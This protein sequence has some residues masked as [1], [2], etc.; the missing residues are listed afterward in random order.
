MNFHYLD[1]SQ[2]STLISTIEIDNCLFICDE[3][4]FK[5]CFKK[6]DCNA[7]YVILPAGEQHKNWQSVELVIDKLIELDLNRHVQIFN[8]GG[9]VICDIGGF[10]A[11]I[12]QRGVRF[13]N[14]PTSLM[15]MVDAAYGGKT[16][17][18]YLNI[19]NYIGSFNHPE[20]IYICPDFLSTLPEREILSA[21]AEIIKH[22]LLQGREH[23]LDLQ[24]HKP[25]DL[26]QENWDIL[27]RQS[28][29]FK[30]T[31]VEADFKD[32]GIRQSLNFGHTIGHG[33]ESTLLQRKVDTA[34]GEAVAAGIICELALS[35]QLLNFP[36]DLFNDVQ[37]RIDSIYTRLPIKKSDVAE[38][39]DYASKD[40]KNSNGKIR[41]CLL[42]DLGLPVLN[43][44]VEIS[45][46]KKVIHSYIEN[47][48]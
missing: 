5:N 33:M 2:I 10:A 43:Q 22:T 39:I 3:N 28:N 36:L 29:Q 1:L 15:A 7:P 12:F 25:L 27:I 34:H 24:K 23:W 16:G 11:S 26:E 20:D 13:Y 14:I 46:I 17:I 45:L 35:V 48:L 47:D 21:Y 6:I 38:I 44:A 9:G 19:K 40:K 8:L 41:C 4:T 32:T 30:W 31:V 37:Q 42:K 18:N